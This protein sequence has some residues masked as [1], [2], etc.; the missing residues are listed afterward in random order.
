MEP[1]RQ[2]C[3]SNPWGKSKKAGSIILLDIRQYY[4][5]T[6][7]KT[8]WYW[9]RERHQVSGAEQRT[10]KWAHIPATHTSL[11]KK[12]RTVNGERQSL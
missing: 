9:Q 11:T 6:V 7:I 10:Q 12:P 8:A 5:A 1:Q 4:E 3:Q 2:N